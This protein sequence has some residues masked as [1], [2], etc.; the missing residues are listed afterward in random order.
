MDQLNTSH[1]T[2]HKECEENRISTDV[3]RDEI[4]DMK[5]R[6]LNI[7]EEKNQLD[8][9]VTRLKQI[10]QGKLEQEK[11]QLE[12]LQRQQESKRQEE[13]LQ[14]QQE[15]LQRQQESQRQNEE[16]QQQQEA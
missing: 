14:R 4:S 10:H 8:R 5:I 1:H 2:L 15:E 6:V 11:R 13:K 9:E 3:C 12:E 7:K 16:L